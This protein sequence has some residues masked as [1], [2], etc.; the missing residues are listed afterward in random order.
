MATASRLAAVV[1]L[2]ISLS[3]LGAT[4]AASSSLKRPSPTPTPGPAEDSIADLDALLA[5]KSQ[6]SDHLGILASSWTTNVSIC[7]WVGVSC[8][9]RR[10]RVTALSLPDVPLQ[11]ELSQ[12]LGNLSFLSLLD[13]TNTNLTGSI[14]ASLGRLRR[15]KYLLLGD[16][17]LSNTIP[18][19]IGNLTELRFLDLKYG[20]H[21]KASRMSDVF[22][23]G[24]MLLEVFT[25]KRPTDPMFDGE[26]SIR[27][28]IHQAFPTDL[29]SV[30]DDQ[31]L[32]DA[33][34]IMTGLNDFLSPIFE[35]GLLCSSDS[36]DQRMTMRDV[37]VRLKKM[38]RDGYTKLYATVQ[39]VPSG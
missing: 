26:L 28:W 25:G 38:K 21:G 5:F 12:H 14:P 39:T 10:Q 23:Y 16:N 22:S 15:L 8:S 24:I 30:I 36:P 3:S 13:L 29:A 7:R 6:L 18:C 1:L 27:Q 11:G 17:G 37:V 4:G 33:S 34:S 9:H 2:A 35:L 19:A 20:T 32:Q 31:L